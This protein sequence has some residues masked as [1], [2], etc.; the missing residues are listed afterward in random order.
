[1]Y[2]DLTGKKAL[3][4]GATGGIGS[5]ICKA[6][7]A[8][9]AELF[10]SGTSNDK[11]AKF[12]QELGGNVKYAACDLSD[13]DAAAKLVDDAVNEMG[14]IDILVCNAGVTEDG[15]AMRMSLESFEKVIKVNLFS[16]FAMNKTAVKYMM[17]SKYGRIINIASVVA[18]SGNPGQANYVAS[19]AGLIGMTKSLAQE[20]ASRNI[21]VNAVAPGFI[22][23]KMTD[24]LSEDQKTKLLT[25]IPAGFLGEPKDI[26]ASVLYLASTEARYVNGH[27]L[28]VNGG[29][30]MV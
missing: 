9:G 14:G 23:T 13:S 7:K 11:L 29:M 2:F 10:I 6:L 4:T 16:A 30:L 1:M 28:H 26:A 12:A 18:A 20:V 5:E 27:T 15:L 17:K 3:I 8:N 25:K 21:T 22:V 19:K 24:A